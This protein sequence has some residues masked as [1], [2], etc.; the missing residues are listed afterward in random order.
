MSPS[1][2][3]RALAA[4]S[5]LAACSGPA[6]EPDAGVDA[7]PLIPSSIAHCTYEDIPPTAGAGGTVASGALMAGV[8][9]AMLDAPLG[10]SLGAYT[11]RAEAF[12]RGGF[13]DDEYERHT[14][15][16]GT[17]APSLGVET[18]PR[19]G[20]LALSA[21]G[22]TVIILKVDLALAYQGFVYDVEERLGPEYSGKILMATSHSHSSYGNYS[23]HSAMQ[24]GFSRFH[25]TV[26]NAFVDQFV[27]TVEAAVADLRPAQ[28]GFAYDGEFDLD[29]RV[30]RDR[31]GEN[32]DL[33]GG[34][35]DDHHL[36]VIRVDDAAGVPIALLP[37]FGMHGTLGGEDNAVISVDAPGGVERILREE[38][39]TPVM[40][41]HLQGAGGDVSPAGSSV[42]DCA[43]AAVCAD[44]GRAET[45]G[46]YARDAILA[47]W[48]VAGE[49]MVSEVEIEMLTRTVALGPDWETFTIRD[50]ALEYA[51]FDL[52]RFA[53]GEVYDADGN[54]ISPIDEF[55][56]P[57]GAALCSAN[58]GD[59]PAFALPMARIRGTEGLGDYPYYGCNRIEGVA[60]VF[61]V[62]FDIDFEETPLC[63]TTRTVV[64]AL[65]IGDWMVGTLPGE[66]VT[67]L[68]DHLRELSPM[69]PERTIIVG[70]AQDHGG[71]L[72]RPED[73]LRG[74]YE[75]TIGFWGPLEGEYVAEQVAALMPL[76]TT[77]ERE[78][79]NELGVQHPAVPAVVDEFEFDVSALEVGSVPAEL[80]P[81]IVT[82]LLRVPPSVQPAAT[83]QRL[84]SVFFTFVGDDP[85]RGTPRVFLQQEVAGVF[86]DM[87]RRSGR[88]VRDGD[89]VMTW[90]PDP[91]RRV[92]GTPR[93]HYYTVEFQ[94]AAPLGMPGLGA[95]GDRLGLP[96]GRYRFRIEGPG[97]E[98]ASDP[99]TVEPASLVVTS[100]VAGADLTVTVGV[101]APEGY[102]LIDFEARSNG[103]VPLRTQPIT[104]VV[105]SMPAVV[106]DTDAAGVLTIPGAAG[107]ASVTIADVHL[108][109]A[110]FAP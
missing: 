1:N 54:I 18:I 49:S 94:A 43:G 103:L 27:A 81:L 66:P 39:D 45:I 38:F 87:A 55:N 17:F 50:G 23:G 28:I 10:A 8:A 96:E 4:I 73:W 78:D 68:V 30:N 95:V 63:E 7:G 2:L 51:P 104:V 83:V 60:N 86:E 88:L 19:I 53:D 13:L 9:E 57:N 101:E 35:E 70:Y 89:F 84:G 11:G 46:H 75:P 33:A 82:R 61:E 98:L 12:G 92:A 106:I 100:A 44:F 71:Y 99:F 72:L 14:Y 36:Y 80:P 59:I 24:V 3:V 22:E 5:L 26:Y 69:P 41:A 32:D 109:T 37:V 52:S 91:I 74:G 29:D 77:A 79:G 48:T 47:A 20:A 97:Y 67:L 85:M 6:P 64:S 107:A 110:T 102:R 58:N 76:A 62:I 15:L 40:V 93:T 34:P 31:R 21:G 42:I 16:A 25:P 108:N 65:R 56:A 90:T 105:D